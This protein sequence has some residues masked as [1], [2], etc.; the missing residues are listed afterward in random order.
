[1]K[2][3]ASAIFLDT[4]GKAVSIY[5]KILSTLKVEGTCLAACED[6]TTKSHNR[7][8]TITSPEKMVR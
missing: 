4:Q 8:A 7:H 6:L 3:N 1:M 2:G 5:W